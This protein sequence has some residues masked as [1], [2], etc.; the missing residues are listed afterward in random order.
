MS[1]LSK[2]IFVGLTLSLA[3][4]CFTSSPSTSMMMPV[5]ARAMALGD[6]TFSVY[7][8]IFTPNG[9]NAN[10]KAA[11]HFDNPQDLPVAGTVYDLH[12]AKVADLKPGTDPAELLLWDGKD[13]DGRTVPSGIYLYQLEYQ[14]KHATGTVVVAR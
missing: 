7:P 8:R 9:D 1:V 2:N 11:F 6:L 3:L 12:G 13:T 10:D 5:A 14:G 4:P